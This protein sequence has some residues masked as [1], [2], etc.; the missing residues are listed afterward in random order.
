M[1]LVHVNNMIS[2]FVSFFSLKFVVLARVAVQ[3][4]KCI[5]K[6]VGII[7]QTL[8]LSCPG[9]SCLKF[10]MITVSFSLFFLLLE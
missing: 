3:A 10:L 6:G 7:N 1:Q 9:V 2:R 5:R 4:G 8:S